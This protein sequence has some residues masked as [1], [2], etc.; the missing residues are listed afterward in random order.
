[1]I[2]NKETLRY[3]TAMKLVLIPME[4]KTKSSII[5]SYFNVNKR[6]KQKLDNEHHSGARYFYL[7]EMM[8]NASCDL[9]FLPRKGV[10]PISPLQYPTVMDIPPHTI[11]VYG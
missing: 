8:G 2:S 9:Y 1:M 6:G 4:D 11:W 10:L 5:T 3:G 7:T